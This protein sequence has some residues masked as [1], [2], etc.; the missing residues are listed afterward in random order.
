MRPYSEPFYQTAPGGNNNTRRGRRLS[1][2]RVA[3]VTQGDLH[4]L[5]L[6]TDIALSSVS[7][8]TGA[9]EEACGLNT[10]MYFDWQGVPGIVFDNH[11]HALYFWYE[12]RQLGLFKGPAQLLHVDAHRDGSVPPRPL[13]DTSTLPD[14]FWYVNNVVEVGS[15]IQ[16][17][18]ANG[19][20]SSW[21]WLNTLETIQ[22]QWPA[23]YVLDLDLDIFAGLEVSEDESRL[24]QAIQNLA[25]RA[26]FMTV[27]TSP[28]YIPQ[29]RAI[30]LAQKLFGRPLPLPRSDH[31][32]TI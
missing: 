17:A 10:F 30:R 22:T 14:V 25:L 26:V 12:A 18:L 5:S 16:P 21:A 13:S 31:P 11:N 19:F 6:S 9:L 3:A 24:I 7:R 32:L 29:D 23:G 4:N 15:F 28:L 2:L 8:A 20:F 27:A 1:P